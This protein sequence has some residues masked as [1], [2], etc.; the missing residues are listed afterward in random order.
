MID[1][2][3]W[4][5]E[6]EFF[7]H[8]SSP[9]FDALY[10][11]CLD[12]CTGFTLDHLRLL[13]GHKGLKRL[14]LMGMTVTIDREV[15]EILASLRSLVF[16]NV[17][18]CTVD[19]TNTS[20]LA[21]SQSCSMLKTLLMTKTKGVD[22]YVLNNLAG[23]IERFRS[24]Q[25]IDLTGSPDFSDEGL[26]VLIQA[27]GSILTELR[28]D[29]C[30]QL[31][32]LS[33]ASLRGRMS[34]LQVLGISYLLI[35]QT[36]YEWITEG[37]RSLTS[38]NLS[39]ASEMSDEILIK[40]GRWCR[41]LQHVNLSNCG[42]ITDGGIVGFFGKFDGALVS[43]DLSGCVACSED[44][45]N[46][47]T[48]HSNTIRTLHT[49]KL[50]GL[51]HI[52]GPRLVAFWN[53]TLVDG[54]LRA[55]EMSC[56][57]KSSVSHRRSMMPHFSDQVLLA[58]P[59]DL[60]RAGKSA[61]SL[62]RR[63]LTSLKL[64][65]A[66][67]VGDVG[68]STFLQQSGE[69]LLH[70]DVSYCYKVTD[71]SLQV[72]A[73]TCHVLTTLIVSGCVHITDVGISALGVADKYR[74]FLR[75]HSTYGA[76][77][78]EATTA[79]SHR[80]ANAWSKASVLVPAGHR[81]QRH[82]ASA[83]AA[84]TS[85]HPRET[86]NSNQPLLPLDSTLST[87]WNTMATTL[88]VEDLERSASLPALAASTSSH[89]PSQE[90]LSSKKKLPLKT[91]TWQSQSL[92]VAARHDEVFTGAI[93]LDA[94]HLRT[95]E[96]N[97]C[98][99]ITDVG[100]RNLVSG[101]RGQIVSLGIRSCD[102]LT[103]KGIQAIARYG[104]RSLQHLDMLNLDYVTT[105]GISTLVARCRLLTTL[106]CD[107]CAFT[108]QEFAQVLR[109]QTNATLDPT[110]GGKG[111]LFAHAHRG[112]CQVEALP[113]PVV[114]YNRFV[115]S[116]SLRRHQAA[117]VLQKFA[118]WI[119]HQQDILLARRRG[120]AEVWRLRRIFQFFQLAIRKARHERQYEDRLAA[121]HVLQ[122]ELPRLY[123]VH[124][125]RQRLRHKRR[126]RVATVTLQRCTR[127]FL[128]R[129]RLYRR[130]QRL[131][132]FYN[133][134]GHLAHK[135]AVVHQARH[136]HRL[137]LAT[138]AF[139]RMVPVRVW[140]WTFRRGLVML[141]R[142]I[143]RV[144]AKKTRAILRRRHLDEVASAMARRRHAAARVLQRN[145]K[146]CLFNKLMVPFICTCCVYAR[147][148]WDDQEWAALLVQKRYRGW[149]VRYRKYRAIV[150][151]SERYLAARKLQAAYRRYVQ[152]CKV[153]P[154]RIAPYRR[155][156]Q[157]SKRLFWRLRPRLCLG[158]RYL[159]VEKPFQR[160]RAA[161][162]RLEVERS[163]REI[164]R[165]E[166]MTRYQERCRATV[167]RLR[168]Q[169]RDRMA[170]R[171]QRFFR[172]YKPIMHAYYKVIMEERGFNVS[173][174][175]A[176]AHSTT[177]YDHSTGTHAHFGTGASGTGK[178]S[179]VGDGAGAAD[180]ST[181]TRKVAAALTTVVTKPAALV[182]SLL[183]HTAALVQ[184]DELI[185]R[186]DE[187][188]LANAVLSYQ[189]KTILQEGI[190]DLHLTV[191][192]IETNSF[193]LRQAQFRNASLPFFEKLPEDLSHHLNLSIFLWVMYGTG[194][195]CICDV[196]IAARPERCSNAAM[197]QREE[198]LGEAHVKLVWHPH[199]HFELRG[200]RS[201]MLNKAAFAV[202]E[203]K[204]INN[205]P[206]YEA[207][208][209]QSKYRL[210]QD[211][212]SLGFNHVS[213]WMT[214][215]RAEEDEA[216]YKFNQITAYNWCDERLIRTVKSFLLT[217]TDVFGL[218]RTFQR[219]LNGRSRSTVTII[220]IFD[221]IGFKLNQVGQWAVAAIQPRRK[222]ELTF[223]EYVH[224]V[225]YFVM[226]SARDMARFLFTAQDTDERGFLRR[227][228][229]V[230]LINL[231]AEGSPFNVKQWEYQY[232]TYH[233]KKLKHQFIANFND[234]VAQN[235]GALWQPQL[236]QQRLKKYNLGIQY[237][238]K[239][240]EQYRVIRENLGIKLL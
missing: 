210:V 110:M 60:S 169:Y 175:H 203:L 3:G 233:D 80:H 179:G 95:V 234:F 70:L 188:K 112:R 225:C 13:R 211:M 43:L 103:D 168:Q 217:E 155:A 150:E 237:W 170:R 199:T 116:V 159:M 75:G 156:M 73:Q 193:E 23:C 227:D 36:A 205:L 192:D 38:L 196:V 220:D 90:T 135:Y 4:K 231:L 224:F 173:S 185:P 201:I 132:F 32:T 17:S 105:Q 130:F 82:T 67:Q 139:A 162:M 120:K 128:V 71:V 154:R 33:L 218:R 45:M 164:R 178:D 144:L 140:F 239:K 10:G 93:H 76:E 65:G 137:I 18:E 1:L 145:L 72:I 214:G 121:V 48:S 56:S 87:A 35:G 54:D 208:T 187:K 133:K 41:Q 209:L 114:Q 89:R 52:S 5:L 122:R 47:I 77:E 223:S 141:Q 40:I 119:L 181:M 61:L 2:S 197:K 20:L 74:D 230:T 143:R 240:M 51:S 226:L 6:T 219:I 99:K 88:Q 81:Q 34:A 63:R 55:F 30:R 182:S 202:E 134:I 125:A 207:M 235:P 194:T 24:L 68:L 190:V 131:Y 25:V 78:L 11:L 50:N 212:T 152:Y 98:G 153:Y 136:V 92:R 127:G 94:P 142:R 57:L 213:V 42:Q 19:N 107:G 85:A 148:E 180:T 238:D 229:F 97:G 8:F 31:T 206:D 109:R 86:T 189:V 37:C 7:R 118:Y 12:H 111:L 146:A 113:R 83:T 163:T 44:S 232:E 186:K 39:K 26:L 124:V 9:Q 183:R 28:I 16:L 151:I 29:H 184:P 27:S 216:M 117:R 104:H 191:G 204:I 129:N 91:T 176:H 174:S 157:N 126:C 22:N 198:Q 138:Q 228:Q 149:I 49:L 158:R 59:E 79:G 106:N 165:S 102:L 69:T 21:L 167:K 123:A 84:T 62:L 66:G 221:H 195:Q 101:L 64:V 171:I 147:N 100:L 46:A 236:L 108:A 160:S 200:E 58:L 166:K 96:L 14:S 15:D 215:R 177:Q 53:K 115:Y 222:R 161:K 172:T